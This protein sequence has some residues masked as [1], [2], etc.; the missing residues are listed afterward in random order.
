MTKRRVLDTEDICV[1]PDW[2]ACYAENLEKY[3]TFMSDDYL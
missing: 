1:W 2:T 3:L